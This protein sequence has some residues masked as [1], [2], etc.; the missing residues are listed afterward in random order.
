[1]ENAEDTELNF[2]PLV[3]QILDGSMP[4]VIKSDSGSP[5]G[6]M[7]KDPQEVELANFLIELTQKYGKFNEDGEG[8]WAGYKPAKDNKV[9]DIGVKCQNCALYE[10]GTS[11]KIIAMPVE[12]EAKCRFAII[13]NGIVK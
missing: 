1:M 6:E 5:V 3:Q 4:V 11:C 2:S 8:V 10:G 7:Q 12:P 13:H 9:K